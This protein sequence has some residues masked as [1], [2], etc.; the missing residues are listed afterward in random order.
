[1]TTATK[2]G[3]GKE[4]TVAL[5]GKLDEAYEEAER[6]FVHEQ[7]PAFGFRQRFLDGLTKMSAASSQASS[8]FTN[9]FTC[10]AIKTVLPQLDVRIH[11]VQIG[12][13]FNFRT[14]SEKVVYPWLRRKEFEGAKSGWQTR[15]FERP[16]AYTMD[17]PENIG[18]IKEPFLTCFDELQ[19]HGQDA[20]RALVF[21]IYRQLQLREKKNVALAVPKIDDIAAIVGL[22]SS[23]FF[24]K[25]KSKGQSRLRVLAIYA[26]YEEMTTQLKRYEG[27]TLRPLQ[28]HAAA[29]A[30]TGAIGD[31]EIEGAGGELFEGIEIKHGIQIT[32]DLIEEVALKIAPH[33]LERYYVLTTH[34]DCQPSEGMKEL[35]RDKAQ[36]LGCQIIPNGVI[37]S[38][39]Y[40]LRLL[41]NPSAVFPHYVKLLSEDA[42]LSHEH[43]V[44][45]NEIVAGR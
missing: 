21:L 7:K 44:A 20:F 33:G 31:I 16:R 34:E 3:L 39:R 42:A 25:Y 11:Q 40:Y 10:L 23:H 6:A 37:P 41:D 27:K 5:T 24:H 12:A 26:I 2:K 1:V 38:I 13:P 32:T 35:L 28:N 18:A 36:R 19:E 45:W 29:D 8:A 4:L 30:Q 22:F 17:F 9:I 15:T 14:V 43:R